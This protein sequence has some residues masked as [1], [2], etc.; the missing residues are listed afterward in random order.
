MKISIFLIFA[1]LMNYISAFASSALLC[2]DGY[3]DNKRPAIP[4]V[5]FR[6]TD[7]KTDRE[8]SPDDII[9]A[10]DRNGKSYQV[11]AEEF[12]SNLNSIEYGLNQWGYSLRDS[13]GSYNL[14]SLDSCLKLL[15]NQ[16]EVIK[17]NLIDEPVNEVLKY[18]DWKKKVQLI[19]EEQKKKY[20]RFTDLIKYRDPDKYNEYTSKV[21]AFDVPRPLL[22]KVAMTV[23]KKSK[24]WVFEKGEISKFLI[25]G[26]AGY[27]VKASH[28]EASSFA[29]MTIDAAML[30]IW[31]GSVLSAKTSASSPGTGMGSLSLSV[32]IFGATLFAVDNDL[33]K[34]VYANEKEFINTPLNIEK[35]THFTLGPIPIRLSLGMRGSN[36]MRWGLDARPLQLQSFLQHYA[37]LDAYA[38]AAVDIL[39][40]GVGVHG[41]LLLISVNTHISGNAHVEYN[42]TLYFKLNLVGKTDVHTLF[43]DLKLVAYAYL[44]TLQFWKG[45]LEKKEWFKRLGEYPGF[46]YS[47]NIFDY[48]ATLS[49][50]GFSAKGQLSI[51][52]VNDHVQ[53]KKSVTRR[54]AILSLEDATRKRA[55]ETFESIEA[56]FNSENNKILLSEDELLKNHSIR[57]NNIFNDY[58]NELKAIDHIAEYL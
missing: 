1:L 14:S 55:K 54:E 16:R 4:F 23:F 9:T 6:M 34:S 56:D 33:D 36:T 57:M 12:F 46:K 30:N 47:G 21:N 15:E 43:G 19:N 10:I 48:S 17:K 35:S 5:P 41:R 28:L 18:D 31:H 25:G 13:T 24:N 50:T 40:A 52:D 26:S 20:P 2:H 22:K 42:D 58:E 29:H 45:I 51:E 38:V 7:N 49:P 44:P 32:N 11:K 37:E 53:I 39:I 3:I 8:L 27:G